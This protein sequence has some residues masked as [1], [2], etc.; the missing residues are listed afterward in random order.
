MRDLKFKYIGARNFMCFGPE[1]IDLELNTLGNIILIRGMNLDVKPIGAEGTLF[2]DADEEEQERLSSNGTG[3]STVA[4]I[5]SWGLF[6]KTIK[7]NSKIKIDAVIHNIIGEKCKVE[8][9]WDK[10]TVI[11]ERPKKNKGLL[12]FLEEQE[13][14]TQKDLTQGTMDATQDKIIKELGLT[15][16]AFVNIC[17]FAD[18]PRMC[19][20][21]SENSVKQEIVETLMSLGECKEWAEAANDLIKDATKTAKLLSHEYELLTSQQ[22]AAKNRLSRARDEEASWKKDRLGELRSFKS[23][24]EAKRKQL[25]ESD[26]GAELLRYQEVQER[27]REIGELLPAKEEEKK[28]RDELLAQADIR[29]EE[30]KEQS[31]LL[32]TEANDLMGR[33]KESQRKADNAQK[34]INDLQEDGASCFACFGVVDKK[35]AEHVI[36]KAKNI[37]QAAESEIQTDTKKARVLTEKI[38]KVTQAKAKIQQGVDAQKEKQRAVSLEI[39]SL[40]KELSTLSQVREPKADSDALLLEQQITSLKTQAV[41]KKKEYEGRSPYA[42]IIADGERELESS[43]KTCENKKKEIEEAEADIPY[44]EYWKE[45]FGPNGIRK[46]VIDGIIPALNTKIEYWLQFLIENK[47]KLTFDNKLKETI[48]RNPRDGEAFVYH[49][50]STGERRRL[51]LAV[52]QSFAHIMRIATGTNP[53]VVFL[54]EVSTNIDPLGVQGIYNMICELSEDKQVFVTTHDQDLLK[55]LETAHVIRL[56]RKDGITRMLPDKSVKPVN[57]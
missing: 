49:A 14:G 29:L 24:I 5:L 16:E 48:H 8:V 4:E 11:R 23:Q 42:E 41:E 20:L 36:H 51:N 32:S 55:M 56:Q 31:R 9:R 39:S 27:L 34:S 7:N 43:K 13:D 46:W 35:N 28:K 25:E 2:P 47:V 44:Y 19:F 54:D 17:I 10:Y 18:D 52:S 6:G 22:E 53:S 12:T 37:I 38:E 21:E 1:G 15:F 26:F 40:S 30:M 45:G 33:I 50:M 3:K 57:I